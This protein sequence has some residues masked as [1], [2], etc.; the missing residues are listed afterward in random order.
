MG[1]RE[2]MLTV[3]AEISPVRCWVQERCFYN[4]DETKTGYE[5]CEIFAISSYRGRP[6]GLNVRI[7]SNGGLF[8]DIP[9][10]GAQTS[11]ETIDDGV[12]EDE[13]IYHD[14]PDN[15]I[16]IN[17]FR[18]LMGP[19]HVKFASRTAMVRGDYIATV[20]WFEDNYNIHFLKLETGQFCFM[21]SHKVVFGQV[22]PQGLPPYEKKRYGNWPQTPV[23]AS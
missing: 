9:V 5:K 22:A 1:G 13:L 4:L 2:S 15:N 18:Y 10:W 8:H 14:C 19:V 20:D 16:T 21:P 17:E 6:L 23:N 11:N 7:L 12:P 3:T